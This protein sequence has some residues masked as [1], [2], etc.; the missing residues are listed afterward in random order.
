LR[1]L[2]E[3]QLRDLGGFVLDLYRFGEQRDRLVREKLDRIIETD[4]ETHTLEVL[5]GI[6]QPSARTYELRIPGVG[7]AC[8][9]CGEF[10]AS[11]SRFC[12]RCGIDLAAA[13]AAAS[14]GHAPPPPEELARTA[15][16]AAAVEEA[17]AGADPQALAPAESA[18]ALAEAESPAGV[19]DDGGLVEPVAEEGQLED[20]EGGEG[21]ALPDDVVAAIPEVAPVPEIVAAPD[22]ATAPEVAPPEERQPAPPIESEWPDSDDERERTAGEGETVELAAV[23]ERQRRAKS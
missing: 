18:P 20:G 2:R 4:K 11:D 7:G 23:R 16:R 13:A 14:A 3:L 9:S 12:A 8:A 6:A 17:A 21:G 5:L 10:H 15:A 22:I 19:S 1:R